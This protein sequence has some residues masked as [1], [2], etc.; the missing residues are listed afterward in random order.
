MRTK[1]VSFDNFVF[2]ATIIFCNI[3]SLLPGAH[4]APAFHQAG[5]LSSQIM[6]TKRS[7]NTLRT[8]TNMTAHMVKIIS[9]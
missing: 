8:P 2:S 4:R 6:H 9:F 5:Q 1:I 7:K 3:L